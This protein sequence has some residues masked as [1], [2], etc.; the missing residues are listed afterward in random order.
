MERFID[1]LG[2]PF[3]FYAIL[4]RN[5]EVAVK[6]P[7]CKG[8]AYISQGE[9]GLMVKC[10]SCFHQEKEPEAYRCSASGVC[11]VC[12]RWF[13]EQVTDHKQ[14]TQKA[15]RIACPHCSAVNQV[16]LR[17]A[18]TYTGCYSDFRDERDPVFQLELYYLDY[19]RSKPV[20]AA[21]W[22]HLN[23]LIRYIS[24]DL[25]EKPAGVIKR[26]ASHSLPAYMKDAKNREAI[27]KLLYK[28]QQKDM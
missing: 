14:Q 1:P 19:F 18:L 26:T 23:Y 7:K 27:V 5:E 28:L 6:C 24:A 22:E 21:N 3:R 13:N 17:R 16:P 8:L 25:R 15:I 10:T 2:L 20:W 4:R 12:E 9:C 11:A